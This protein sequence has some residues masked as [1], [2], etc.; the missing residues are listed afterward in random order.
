MDAILCQDTKQCVDLTLD[1][2]SVE[3]TQLKTPENRGETASVSGIRLT[4]LDIHTNKQ[5]SP[6]SDDIRCGSLDDVSSNVTSKSAC[7][8]KSGMIDIVR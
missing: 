6:G 7:L 2:E 3:D 1:M 8:S 4:G 5:N